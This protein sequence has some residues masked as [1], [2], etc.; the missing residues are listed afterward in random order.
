RAL[1]GGEDPTSS[2]PVPGHLPLPGEGLPTPLASPWGGSC[3][4][5]ADEGK[6]CGTRSTV[7]K[8]SFHFHPCGEVCAAGEIRPHPPRSGPPSPA[9]G[10]LAHTVGFPL[11]GMPSVQPAFSNWLL[12]RS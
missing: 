9:R 4:A 8:R 5:A 7:Q 6:S 1:G 10:R 2:G 3:R 11:G 12:Y